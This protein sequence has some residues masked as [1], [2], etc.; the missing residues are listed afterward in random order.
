MNILIIEDEQATARHIQKMLEEIEPGVKILG[1]LDS[2]HSAVTW[3]R[4]H[5]EPDLLLCDIQLAD[6]LSFDIFR[7]VEI[8]CPVIFATAY[9][10]YAIQA[11]R[12]NSID[13][14]LK[15]ISKETLNE[16][17]RKYRKLNVGI[18]PQKIDYEKLA[19]MIGGAGQGMLKRLV[20]RYGENI[21]P[22]DI[23][24][25]AY[26]QTEEKIVFLKTF[27]N[28]SYPVDFTLDEL[29]SRLDPMRW[30]RINRQF[31]ISFESIEKMT[32]YS[33]SRIKITLRPP[34]V[35]E[36][37]SSTERSGDFKEWLA[38]K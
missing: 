27:E 30:F 14:L 1:I 20:I 12:V 10:Q 4:T 29:E 23:R 16:A 38:G 3:F 28:K 2:I 35:I 19:E 33:K 36:T 15:P 17:L 8:S 5:G 32:T 13:Y 34:C 7:E 11:F 21:K 22:V 6:G 25:V 24:D 18:T 31:I 37:I 26:F 9:D